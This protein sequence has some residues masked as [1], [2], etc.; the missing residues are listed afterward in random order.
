MIFTQSELEYQN[1]ETATLAST[2]ERYGLAIADMKLRVRRPF[3]M[4]YIPYGAYGMINTVSLGDDLAHHRHK[5]EG[6]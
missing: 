5:I 2:V 3:C 1:K 4:L 6:V